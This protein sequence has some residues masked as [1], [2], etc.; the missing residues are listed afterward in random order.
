VATAAC[1]A[2]NVTRVSSRRALR[3][4]VNE[5][6]QGELLPGEKARRR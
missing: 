1:S 6:V 3:E 4:Y 5:N 2:A